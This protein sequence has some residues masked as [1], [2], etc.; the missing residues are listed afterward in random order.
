MYE[1]IDQKQKEENKLPPVTLEI[2]EKGVPG[3]KLKEAQSFE[4]EKGIRNNM[5]DLELCSYIDD[6]LVPRVLRRTTDA[7]LYKLSASRRAELCSWIWLKFNE[8]KWKNIPGKVFSNRNITEAQL[9][10]CLDI[11]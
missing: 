7:S 9:R 1:V 6:E 5:T 2:I 8:V 4:K 10:R 3:F 11:R